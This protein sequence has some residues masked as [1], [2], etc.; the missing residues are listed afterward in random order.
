MPTRQTFSRDRLHQQVA[1]HLVQ[2]LVSGEPPPGELLP[3]EQR[4]AENLGVSRTVIREALMMVST[5]G[6]IEIEHGRGAR[7]R[8]AT[9]WNIFDPAV[10]EALQ[11]TGGVGPIL[12]NLLEVRRFIEVEAA[13][14][15]A[16]RSDDGAPEA[17][18]K[19]VQ[20]MELALKAPADYFRLDVAFHEQLFQAA[21]NQV[22]VR[23]MEP[24]RDLLRAA[25]MHVIAV[26]SPKSLRESL[27]GHRK[28]LDAIRAR[29]QDAARRAMTDHLRLAEAELK[30]AT[31]QVGSGG[32]TRPKL[33]SGEAV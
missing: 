26:S 17:L 21:N 1:H 25:R 20:E 12:G 5:K 15:A 13:A 6:L 24:V 16:V 30:L 4:L 19:L 18:E 27:E 31:R 9:E 11:N 23:L 2:Q 33:V 28:I 7:V 10:I 14:L 22:L 32:A 29:D 3:S 8:R